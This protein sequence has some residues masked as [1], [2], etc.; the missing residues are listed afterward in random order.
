MWPPTAVGQYGDRWTFNVN[1]VRPDGTNETLGP[2]ESDPVGT[3]Y[4]YYTPD[5]IGEY[6]FQAIMEE[7]VID[8]GASR[9]LI[10]PGGIGYWPGGSPTCT[11]T[12]QT[13]HLS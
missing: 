2:F 8:G 11:A 1:V 4:T 10:S 7:H 6:L 9:G 5:Q 13:A 12:D 3:G